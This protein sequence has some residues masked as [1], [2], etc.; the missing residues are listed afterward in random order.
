MLKPFYKGLLTL[1]QSAKSSV[2]KNRGGRPAK[3]AEPSRPITVTLP[4]RVLNLLA[5]VDPDRAKA[6]TR[7][8]DA[9]A[10]PR[11][12]FPQPVATVT[13]PCHRRS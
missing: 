3:F 9:L 1:K 11:G 12:K 13:T 4:E 6:I 10:T 2:E 5:A 7:L 8:V